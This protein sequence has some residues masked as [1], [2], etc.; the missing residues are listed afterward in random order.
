MST[1]EATQSDFTGWR[2]ALWPIH[3]HEL[4]KFLPLAF[5]MFCI[6]FNYTLLRDTKDTIVVNSAGAGAISFLKLYCV[7]PA[8]ILFVIFYA[9]L[10]NILSRENV[11]YAVVMPFLIFFGAFAFI[12]YPN[13]EALHPSAE[14]IASL[15]MSYPALIG[16]IDI[17]AYWAFSLFYVLAE[18]W[19]SAMIALMFWQFANHVVRMRESKRFYGLFA[20]IGNVSLIVS[21][22]L[23]RYCSEDI[24]QF[25]ATPEEAWQMS[26]Y[27]LMG[28]VVVF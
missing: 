10:T 19:G 11:F 2:A 23:V 7:T 9:K 22:Q 3:N 20:V 18:I 8:A 28:S 5:I 17:Y 6:L 21:G 15:K 25:Y 16:F 13:L 4:K 14:S 12:I 1:K 26:L 27:L 24:K